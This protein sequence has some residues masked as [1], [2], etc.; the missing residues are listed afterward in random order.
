MTRADRSLVAG[1]VRHGRQIG[2]LGLRVDCRCVASAA[3]PA[4]LSAKA[5]Q[6]TNGIQHHLPHCR[7][8]DMLRSTQSPEA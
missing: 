3:Q 5:G 8:H 6:I 2:R 7:Q 4:S 1:T